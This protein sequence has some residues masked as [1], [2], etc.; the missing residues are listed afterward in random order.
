MQQILREVRAESRLASAEA[1]APDKES[2]AK[3]SGGL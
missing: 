2:K 3:E 1:G